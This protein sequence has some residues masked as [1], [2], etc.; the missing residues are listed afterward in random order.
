MKSRCEINS[1]LKAEEFY[2]EYAS[3]PGSKAPMRDRIG[4]SS[5]YVE[6]D[7]D[8]YFRAGSGKRYRTFELWDKVIHP[9][10]KK[11]HIIVIDKSIN[12]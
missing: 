5:Q 8:S 4:I 10:D 3:Q 1:R 6:M 12:I 7:G 11:K 9:E 2:G